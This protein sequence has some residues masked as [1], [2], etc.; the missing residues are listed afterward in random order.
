MGSA[1]DSKQL[2]YWENLGEYNFVK[3]IITADFPGV[4]IFLADLD[5]DTDID[6]LSMSHHPSEYVWFE[7]TS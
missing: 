6:V 1:A 7:N 5:G 3:K 4:G 2:V